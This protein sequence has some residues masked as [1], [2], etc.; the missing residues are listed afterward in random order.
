VV[1]EPVDEGDD[2]GCVGEDGVPILEGEVGGDEQGA[3]L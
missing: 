1:G 2:A 3:A